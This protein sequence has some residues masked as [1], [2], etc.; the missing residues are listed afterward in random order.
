MMMILPLV[1]EFINKRR[2]GERVGQKFEHL[3]E[4]ILVCECEGLDV[5]V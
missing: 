1:G 4:L 5:G 3:S 2:T